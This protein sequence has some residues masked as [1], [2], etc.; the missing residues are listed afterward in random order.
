MPNWC[1]CELWISG[2]KESIIEFRD[3]AKEKP[4]EKERVQPFLNKEW[5]LSALSLPN[6][7]PMPKELE[8]TDSPSKDTN[9]ELIAKYGAD[10]W[11]EWRIANW[12]IKWDV[13]AKKE[14]EWLEEEDASLLYQFDAPWG[15]PD[16]W[17]E[18]VAAMYPNLNFRLKYDEP[19]MAFMGVLIGINGHVSDNCLNY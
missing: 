9:S 12:G 11:Y 7:V 14:D 1:S 13:D 18:K 2:P 17:L 5:P 16:K 8:E 19:G 3:M 15:P 6:F 10:N 4:S